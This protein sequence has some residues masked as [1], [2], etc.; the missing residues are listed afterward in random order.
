MDDQ[1]KLMQLIQFCCDGCSSFVRG[2]EECMEDNDIEIRD[3]FQCPEECPLR[4]V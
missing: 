3:I 2:T 4:E 1:D